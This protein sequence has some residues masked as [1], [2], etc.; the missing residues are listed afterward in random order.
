MLVKICGVQTIETAQVVSDAGADFIGF[1]FA[2]STR[3]ITPEKAARIATSIPSH[4]KTV[5]VFVN[6]TVENMI[7]IATTVGLDVIQLHG[8]ETPEMIASLP[9]ETIKA[10]SIDK[11]DEETLSIYNADYF[12]IDSPPT[13]HRGGSGETFNWNL[14]TRLNIDPAKLILAGG[15]AVDNIDQ[16]IKTVQPAGVDVSSGVETDGYKDNEKI[17]RFIAKAKG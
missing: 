15:L 13:V 4:V 10:F 12:I 8:D 17:K 1:V 2:P 11:I 6:E 7:D 9:Y 14:A 3:E 16:A 5:G